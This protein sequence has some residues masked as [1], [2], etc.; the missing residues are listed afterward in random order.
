MVW[1]GRFWFSR[2]IA[3]G[4]RLNVGKTGPSITFGPRGLKVT[5]GHG[6]I[7]KTVGIPGTGLSWTEV[8]P[9]DGAPKAAP[10]DAAGD[11]GLDAL[12]GAPSA[13]HAPPDNGSVV[14]DGQVVQ[15][16]WAWQREEARERVAEAAEVEDEVQRE[17]RRARWY[18]AHPE[19]VDPDRYHGMDRALLPILDVI[20]RFG[21]R[22]EFLAARLGTTLADAEARL[23]HLEELGYVNAPQ[24][25]LGVWKIKEHAWE[26]PGCASRTSRPTDLTCRTCNAPLPPPRWMAAPAAGPT[27]T[28]G[29]AATPEAPG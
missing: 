2:K 13:Y 10:R 27:P 28:A 6:R 26:C 25:H 9:I 15:S 3:P 16:S 23:R 17:A 21:V 1:R 24:D 8:T 14:E 19:P 22:A 18:A 12:L 11:H 7:R 4:I 20:G 5:I 29:D